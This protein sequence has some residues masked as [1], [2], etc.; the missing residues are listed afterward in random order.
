VNNIIQKLFFLFFILLCF[1]VLTT[2]K[3]L[4]KAMFVITGKVTDVLANSAEAS[5]Q[6][7]DMGEG[8]TQYGHCYAKTPNVTVDG[9]KTQLGVPTGIGSFTSQLTN[10]EAG[11][12]YYIKAYISNG[13]E[14]VY[15]KEIY[16]NTI[17]GSPTITTT[18]ITS[19]TSVTAICGGSISSDGGASVT[20]R[21]V[22]WNTST[23]PTTANNK[24]TDGTGTGSFASSL[25]DLSIN[26]TYYVRAYATNSVGTAYGNQEYFTTDP[27]T[28]TDIDGNIYNV[29][30]IGK[31]LWMKE[32]LKTIK[33]NDATTIPL[34]TDN[35]A[36]SNLTTPGYCL[37]DNDAPTYKDTYGILYNW[38]AASTTNLCP[39][40]WHVPSDD[41][42]KELERFLGMS[43]AEADNYGL[44]GTDE[45]GK[46]KETS[47]AYW[48]SPNTGATNES[49]FSALGAGFRNDDGEFG[50]IFIWGDWWSASMGSTTTAWAR[51]LHYDDA[52]VY[53]GNYYK[54]LGFS[55]R[56]IKN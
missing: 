39:T 6:V 8:A 2:C 20:A 51:T 36:W 21:G 30:R 56:C 4:E 24:T 11:T 42:W 33:Y 17:V 46:L 5:G 38:Y 16:F 54:K 14:T 12:Q 47:T 34:V 1:I 31:Q 23:S 45:G 40:G 41:E 28:V 44:R 52:K 26:T 27:T 13:N 43:H 18:A 50:N 7:I 19:V 49:N 48:M 29:V 25:T 32:N 3:K 22:C 37:Y 10:L 35:T 53:R 15:G 55:V 9:S